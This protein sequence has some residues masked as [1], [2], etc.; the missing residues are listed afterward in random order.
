MSTER[1]TPAGQW[2]QAVYVNE[3]TSSQQQI[4]AGVFISEDGGVTPPVVGTLTNYF[5]ACGD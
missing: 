3:T 2:G 1:Q 5:F 4:P